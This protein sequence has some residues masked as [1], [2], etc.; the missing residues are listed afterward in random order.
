MATD[1]FNKAVPLFLS[2][3]ADP[4]KPSGLFL[5]TILK[6]IFVIF[7]AAAIVFAIVSV[8][9]PIALFARGAAS[10]V[11]TAGSPDGVDQSMHRI[12]SSASTQA[13][14]PTSRE[15][16]GGDELLAA[17]VTAFE[18]QTEVEQQPTAGLFNKFQAW[19]TKEDTQVQVQPMHSLQDARAQ[20][21]Q[22]APFQRAPKPSPIQRARTA[23]AQDQELQNTQWPSRSFGWHD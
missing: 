23:R 3:Q 16:P 4:P 18:S 1:H 6:T 21:V 17:F 10:Q 19:A 14:P 13:L 5:S 11:S 9:N 2:D 15:A 12:Q 8:G 20:V 22:K 7:A